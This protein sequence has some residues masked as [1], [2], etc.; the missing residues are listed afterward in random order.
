VRW[1]E[2]GLLGAGGGMIVEVLAIFRWVAVWQDA[3]RDKDGLLLP[4]PPKLAKY[5]DIPAHALMLPAR[6]VLGAVAAILFGLTGQVTGPY[7]ALAFGCA[8][9]VLLSRLGLI[10][11]VSKAVDGTPSDQDKLQSELAA[12]ASG[13]PSDGSRLLWAPRHFVGF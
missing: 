13:H 4:T 8:A 10:P 9:P 6:M 3:R 11:Q 5:V 1:W 7:G 12:T 2:F